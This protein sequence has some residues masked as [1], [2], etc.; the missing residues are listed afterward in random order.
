MNAKSKSPVTSVMKK[1]VV[2]AA[3]V[4]GALVILSGVLLNMDKSI[5]AQSRTAGVTSR[6]SFASLP[7]YDYIQTHTVKSVA[8]IVPVT[9]FEAL[10]EYIYIRSH[11]FS[12]SESMVVLPSGLT[13]LSIYGYIQAHNQI[14]VTENTFV[15]NAVLPE[16][17][18]ALPVFGYI[19]SH[20]RMNAENFV[21]GLP[22]GMRVLPEAGYLQMHEAVSR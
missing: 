9:G 12:S 17:I 16:G 14:P 4:A 11:I 10:P 22:N 2:A 8:R 3:L 13:S 19:E 18:K 6:Q 20:N 1:I 15:M 5:N 21:A 7:E